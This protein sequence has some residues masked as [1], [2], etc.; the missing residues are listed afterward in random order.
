MIKDRTP[1]LVAKMAG[2]AQAFMD[3]LELEFAEEQLGLKMRQWNDIAKA[4]GVKAPEAVLAK[5]QARVA[6]GEGEG[7]S[8][9]DELAQLRKER[10]AENARAQEKLAQEKAEYETKMAS[11]MAR[12]KKEQE[13][14]LKKRE[15]AM[16][17]ELKLERE[18]KE[19]K[20]LAARKAAMESGQPEAQN[21]ETEDD[22]KK[23]L[24]AD[25]QSEVARVNGIVDNERDRQSQNLESLLRAKKERKKAAMDKSKAPS[26]S[27]TTTTTTTS[28]ST[29][30]PTSAIDQVRDAA[31]SS[32]TTH[33][34]VQG[35]GSH[36]H[37][38]TTNNFVVQQQQAA[39][40][41]AAASS[42]SG[43]VA[44]AV[45][46]GTGAIPA[47][48][49]PEYQQ[50]VQVIVGQLV[51][52]PIMEK[53]VKIEKMVASQMPHPLLSYYVDDRDR[54]IKDNEGRLE[55]IDLSELTTSQFVVYCFA[56][57]V[58][59]NISRVGIQVPQ[60]KVAIAKTL[61][62]SQTLSLIHI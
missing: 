47:A 23:R 17:E 50:W 28:H 19:K 57:S 56:A 15:A 24:L 36:T 35:E 38:S 43:N 4:T 11:E 55:T 21:R 13:D 12:L 62:D 32:S 51:N 37:H 7:T 18:R 22:L 61:P 45:P 20:L 52:S 3:Q 8:G 14:E 27:S 5:Y 48:N 25:Y 9:D 58:R 10:E 60:V 40:S 33:V 1:E 41:Q 30:A 29:A 42:S 31:H 59:E 53:V 34:T 54:K 2:D 39:A 16:L 6:R 46:G 49:S 44:V 26:S